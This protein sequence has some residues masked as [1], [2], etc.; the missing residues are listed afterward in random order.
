VIASMESIFSCSTWLVAPPSADSCPA[1]RSASN[2]NMRFTL[3]TS[4]SKF[5]LDVLE[6]G[7]QKMVDLLRVESAR[8]N[9]NKKVHDVSLETGHVQ[10]R[11]R[12]GR[13]PSL[14]FLLLFRR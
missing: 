14:G 9:L 3:S 1:A 13:D 8:S 5:R 4:V 10:K 2:A 6:M 7:R 11:L 12:Q